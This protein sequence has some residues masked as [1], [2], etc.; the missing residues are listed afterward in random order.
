M[1]TPLWIEVGNL[2]FYVSTAPYLTRRFGL[3]GL[4]F[5]R[6][7]AFFLFTTVLLVVLERRMHLFARAGWLGR[8]FWKVSASCLVMGVVTWLEFALLRDCFNRQ[9]VLGRAAVVGVLAIS[10]ATVYLAVSYWL[11]LEEARSLVGRALNFLR[12][13]PVSGA[14]LVRSAPYWEKFR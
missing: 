14:N 13:L 6:A 5:A 3:A 8:Q 2:V 4:A 9:H 7:V 12:T 11:Q 1:L 10:G